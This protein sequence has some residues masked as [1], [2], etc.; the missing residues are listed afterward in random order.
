MYEHQYVDHDVIEVRNV[1]G[2]WF[3]IY[4]ICDRVS[5]MLYIICYMVG[6]T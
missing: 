1:C 6:S 2:M 5:G 3:V 4:V